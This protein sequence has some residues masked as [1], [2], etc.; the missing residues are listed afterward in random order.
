MHRAGP[1]WL[2]PVG[3]GLSSIIL[4]A[5]GQS[6]FIVPILSIPISVCGAVLGLAG[7]LSAIWRVD[8]NLRLSVAGSLISGFAILTVS[9]IWK[10][11]NGY[12]AEPSVFPHERPV[13]SGRYVAP[14]AP[15]EESP[16]MAQLPKR[17]ADLVII[18]WQS[19]ARVRIACVQP[20]LAD[21][22]CWFA[23][24]LIEVLSCHASPLNE[25]FAAWLE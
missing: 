12:F 13:V 20:S 2:P 1:T 17:Y 9:A 10:A 18:G 22:C 16:L 4:G 19:S 21:R 15:V 11:P 25:V 3:I 23:E 14:P 24:R 6:L 8:A 5:V 7:I